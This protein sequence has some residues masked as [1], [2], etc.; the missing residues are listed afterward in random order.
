MRASLGHPVPWSIKYVEIGNEDNLY[1]GETTYLEYRFQAYYDAIKAKY[2]DIIVMGS[3]VGFGQYKG[4]ADD[5]HQYTTPD[6]FVSQFDYFD[7]LDDNNR[8]L[9]GK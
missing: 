6:G 2:P 3:M 9:N 7:Q 1:D 5:Y 4:A 8:T